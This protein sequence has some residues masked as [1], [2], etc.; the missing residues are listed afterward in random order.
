MNP[1]DS[2]C[3]PLRFRFLIRSRRWSPHPDN[4][5]RWPVAICPHGDQRALHDRLVGAVE[6][7]F[8]AVPGEA[9]IFQVTPDGG[10]HFL[11][12]SDSRGVRLKLADF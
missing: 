6:P 4:V 3:G 2:R 8:A 5:G 12:V 7:R 9:G 11:H 10:E 1:S